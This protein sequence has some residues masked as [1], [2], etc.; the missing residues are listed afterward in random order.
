MAVAMMIMPFVVG[1]LF[2][3]ETVMFAAAMRVAGTGAKRAP[4]HPQ[5]QHG[6]HGEARLLDIGH[7]VH[8]RPGGKTCDH[9]ER[10]NQHDGGDGLHGGGEEGKADAAPELSL[11]RQQPGGDN[12]LAMAG[13][14]RMEDAVEKGEA[15][16]RGGRRARHLVLKGG[17]GL[18]ERAIG[19]R[20]HLL[21]VN[22]RFVERARGGV[23]RRGGK[24]AGVG[25]RD[26]EGKADQESKKKHGPERFLQGDR[27]EDRGDAHSAPVPVAAQTRVA[28]AANASPRLP[29]FALVK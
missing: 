18:G 13:P 16:K 9:G 10:A 21:D 23:R 29:A 22:Q 1:T 6:H 24:H 4:D 25:G 14:E 17:R 5:A 11:A 12:G 3:F 27:F 20:L 2:I 28:L 26:A 8:G 15:H 19:L 7:R